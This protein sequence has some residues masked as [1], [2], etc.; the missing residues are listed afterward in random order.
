MLQHNLPQDMYQIAPRDKHREQ[1]MK[2]NITCWEC[3]AVEAPVCQLHY[4]LFLQY[5]LFYL[6]TPQ[7]W[8]SR[9]T[10]AL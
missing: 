10:L 2:H 4:G 7:L 9:K 3:S 1:S 5:I 8:G 6:I